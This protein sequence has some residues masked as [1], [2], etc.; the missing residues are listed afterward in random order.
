MHVHVID[1]REVPAGVEVDQHVAAWDELVDDHPRKLL[2]QDAVRI[3]GKTLFRFV[4][5]S[6]VFRVSDWNA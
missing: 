5:S 1:R 3:A 6:G 2:G 4:M